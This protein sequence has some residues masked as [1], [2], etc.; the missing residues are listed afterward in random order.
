LAGEERKDTHNYELNKVRGRTQ[1]RKEIYT[2][3][4]DINSKEVF[5]NAIWFGRIMCV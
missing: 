4:L 2:Y 3:S 1:K 5:C